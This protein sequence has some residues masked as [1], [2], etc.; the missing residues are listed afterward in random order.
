LL[1]DF[2]DVEKA[3]VSIAEAE[4]SRDIIQVSPGSEYIGVLTHEHQPAAAGDEFNQRIDLRR[5]KLR[6]GD[7]DDEDVAVA[8]RL[9][10]DLIRQARDI[11]K[12]REIVVENAV[13]VRGVVAVVISVEG[14][15]GRFPS[16]HV[17]GGHVD[18][19]KFVEHHAAFLA[20]ADRLPVDA[21]RQ[22]D[23]AGKGE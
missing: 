19:M 21:H 1:E 2:V 11:V 7:F 20:L 15:V 6:G 9:I 14:G 13:G 22:G 3:I 4:S 18:A 10:V 5:L 23:G 16:V 12:V 17:A 8:E